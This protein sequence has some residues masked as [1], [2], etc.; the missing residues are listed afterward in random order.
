[1][2][3]EEQAGLVEKVFWNAVNDDEVVRGAAAIL[4]SVLLGLEGA[5]RAVEA[6]IRLADSIRKT[7]S[8]FGLDGVFDQLGDALEADEAA[9]EAI[10]KHLWELHRVNPDWVE[11]RVAPLF[12]IDPADPE[13]EAVVRGVLGGDTRFLPAEV[14]VPVATYL[15]ATVS[16]RTGGAR[17]ASVA[18][19]FPPDSECERAAEQLSDLERKAALVFER[20]ALLASE[21]PYPK[22]LGKFVSEAP[23]GLC[24][25]W[26]TRIGAGLG[27]YPGAADAIWELWAR[28]YVERRVAGL[29]KLLDKCEVRAL[30]EWV[31]AVPPEDFD[32]AVGLLEHAPDIVAAR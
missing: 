22:W 20:A 2:A 16:T 31:A 30:F 19:L 15:A 17:T 10:G 24:A 9:R 6:V 26:T 12:D 8:T 29:P 5:D 13:A 21:D 7:G 3:L 32:A 28:S 1:M 23:P 25:Y 4:S 27:Q 14:A 11:E 18:S